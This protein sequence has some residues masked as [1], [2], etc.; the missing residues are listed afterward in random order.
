MIKYYKT[1]LIIASVLA[2]TAANA[3]FNP[4]L[5]D[6]VYYE[7]FEAAT[8]QTSTSGAP[9]WVVD[10]I[11]SK[12]GLKSYKGKAQQ[13][14]VSYLE[15]NAFSTLNK[16]QVWLDFEHIS[17]ILF[18]N[19][20]TLEISGDNGATWTQ[21]SVGTTGNTKYL[22][23]GAPGVGS[24]TGFSGVATNEFSESAYSAWLAGNPSSP[25]NAWW[26]HERFD[27]STLAGNKAAVKIRFK[28]DDKGSGPGP[29]A[30]R[31]GWLVD[32]IRI[33]RAPSELDPP[34][35]TLT[36]PLLTG[37]QFSAGPFTI[38]ASIQDASS[39]RN[40]WVMFTKTGSP[41]L[42][43]VLM[44][45]T[46]RTGLNYLYEGIL[47]NPKIIDGDELC[48]YVKAVD[49]SISFN[50]G[51]GPLAT[52]AVN[53][54]TFKASGAPTITQVTQLT[55]NQFFTGPFAISANIVDASG[56]ANASVK[57]TINGGGLQ[58]AAM[59]PIFAGSNVFQGNM[60]IFSMGDVVCYYIEAADASVRNNL[61]RSPL[62]TA[63]P[64]CITF[65]VIG[66]GQ[67]IPYTDTFD[68]AN[69]WV[70]SPATGGWELGT[71]TKTFLN[72]TRSGPNA[73]TT[74]LTGNYVASATNTLTSPVFFFNGNHNATFVFWQKRK[75]DPGTAVPTSL[76]SNGDAFYIE[77][78]QDVNNANPAWTTLGTGT[79]TDQFAQ[80]NWY[81]RSNISAPINKPGWNAQTTG[82]QRC[83]YKLTA[84]NNVGNIKFRFVFRSNTT[85]QD[86]G[87]SIDD[88][89]INLPF[90]NDA[91]A[92]Q[93]IS[94]RDEVVAG[95]SIG[96]SIKFK[97]FG[98]T[99]IATV[100]VK[101]LINGNI[102][103][104]FNAT[105]NLT[106][107]ANITLTAAQLPKFL[108]PA[109]NF[110][111][112]AV[113]ALGGDGD[114]LNDTAC[115][116]FYGVPTIAPTFSDNFD[117]AQPNNPWRLTAATN[118]IIDWQKG[119]PTKT[120]INAAASAPN[121]YVT[122]L[123][124][125][126]TANNISWLTTP[127]IDFSGKVNCYLSFKQLRRLANG[128]VARIQYSVD[129]G[130]TWLPLSGGTNGFNWFNSG[131]GFS[132]NSAGTGYIMS[133]FYLNQF[134][135][136]TAKV[137]FR[138]EMSASSAVGEG[139][140]IDDFKIKLPEPYD[141]G[142]TAIDT[143]LSNPPLP[144]VV[145]VR[146][147]V[148]NFGG[149][150]VTSI[151]L[152]Y[153]FN[154]NEQPASNFVWTGSL[155]P[156][157]TTVIN[158]PSYP[159]VIVGQYNLRVYTKGST[160]GRLYNDTLGRTVTGLSRFEAKV[161]KISNPFA[162]KCYPA[163]LDNPIR[164]ELRNAGHTTI[165]TFTANYKLDNGAL[166][167]Q[168]FS[169]VNIPRDSTRAFTFT[170]KADI[171][172]GAHSLKIH[173]NRI[174]PWDTIQVN[175][176]T[177]K[178]AFIAI[179][180]L[181]LNYENNFDRTC[182][183]NQL[184]SVLCTELAPASLINCELLA[185][186]NGLIPGY[187]F[188]MGVTGGGVWN[189]ATINNIWNP[190]VNPDF[191]GRATL[192]FRSTYQENLHIQ[193]DLAQL[194][195]G[196]NNSY[197]RVL[198]NGVPVPDTMFNT[199]TRQGDLAN[200]GVFQ[201]LNYDLSNYYVPGDP[202]I[203]ELQ[204]KCQN[205]SFGGGTAASN[206][207]FIDNV[208]VYNQIPITVSPIDIQTNPPLL[209]PTLPI[210]VKT[211]IKNTGATKLNTIR[212]SLYLNG[213]VVQANQL[214]SPLNNLAFNRTTSFN[215][216][217]TISPVAGVNE[218]CVITSLP[219][220]QNDMFVDDDTTCTTIVAFD[221]KA[222]FPYCN[223]FDANDPLWVTLNSKT[224]KNKGNIWQLGAP[225]KPFI[226]GA[227]SGTRSWATDL[228]SLYSDTLQSALYTP[229]F[230]MQA[231]DC[232]LIKFQ[233]KYQIDSTG[234][235]GTIEYTIDNGVTWHTI[236]NVGDADWYNQGNISTL[237]VPAVGTQE[238]IR[239]K[240]WTG[241]SGGWVPARRDFK[242]PTTVTGLQNVI[243]RFRFASDFTSNPLAINR[244]GWAVDDF[245][246]EPFIGNC[247]PLATDDENMDLGL[248]LNA[249][250][251]N[252]TSEWCKINYVLPTAG[253]VTLSLK[254]VLG[255]TIQ[256]HAFGKQDAGN[257]N[258]NLDLSNL[259]SGIYFYTVDFEGMQL[260][261]KITL[262]K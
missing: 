187:G 112:C 247:K 181:P 135:N 222:Q 43:S 158:M 49:S 132:G 148:K 39:V 16:F 238:R 38:K 130:A 145:Q 209:L 200:S 48:Y 261:Q 82:W 126:Y 78:T 46:G 189:A 195:V 26:K 61:A 68:G 151:P 170:T 12:S 139:I 57:F 33:T 205:R 21:V 160:D 41:A 3:Q 9:A 231:N 156:G 56:I 202:I 166:V 212:A 79:A 64:S 53:C 29:G 87:V 59:S 162:T 252:P 136:N 80:L 210:T 201:A 98:A 150:T 75:I 63:N 194:A 258:F 176:D 193:F 196:G 230:V 174:A 217:N 164:F 180:P 45:R 208:L 44:S 60:P 103:Q 249:A 52:A 235:G 4:A 2:A 191:L 232:Y 226:N 224:Y 117:V 234:D 225:N 255:K 115:F 236:G 86:E 254:D 106:P 11:Y 22:N 197:F 37:L 89:A 198:C 24:A 169:G 155:A 97:N 77:Y 74:R 188:E 66:G 137:K 179:Q 186:N 144:A 104:S 125:N 118:N 167:T 81:N 76:T 91:G 242:L 175:S 88:L 109:Y 165:N 177:L 14:S 183:N 223:N 138:V 240:G 114:A 233:H 19:G 96:V 72:N 122:K 67:L 256:N 92:T 142:V 84:L 220:N 173:I 190:T 143:P 141:V 171:A 94:P 65:T 204:S 140:A 178:V 25:T 113:T 32:D 213:T 23:T 207:N 108:A 257:H 253:K 1:L 50:V 159:S 90:A 105:V 251:P 54:N 248:E 146:V 58:S 107:G 13:T 161:S 149:T 244:E 95:D 6:T 152:A 120:V 184:Y 71:P 127:L 227:F 5:I 10:N 237:I 20:G 239:G 101:Y 215:F 228:D 102:T 18:S 121:A 111:F 42:D 168:V 93:I 185:N 206:G 219:N 30:G 47:Q 62:A 218:V 124:G 134:D 192:T 241:N 128:S 116:N 211:V 129:N 199:V 15:T 243:F 8:T 260:T 203:I 147:K 110:S 70:A 259:E 246:V 250:Y 55:G 34:V 172:L 17:K 157:A 35:V 73:W 85:G 216:T 133:E 163:G 131:N 119:A 27:I 40:A 31:Y 7:D 99:P 153:S 262:I 28:L 83:E 123:A 229:V 36:A 69:N 182:A 214:V 221:Q 245:C 154:G 51:R 100:P